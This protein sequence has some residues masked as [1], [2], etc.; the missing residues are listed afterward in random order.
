MNIEQKEKEQLIRIK[1]REEAI[2]YALSLAKPN[3]IVLIL[4]KGR[5]NYM[6]I[7]NKKI[8]YC[9][10]DVVENYFKSR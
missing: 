8:K 3:S 7:G 9:D 1:N 5:D 10:Y 4:G 2:K 6:A